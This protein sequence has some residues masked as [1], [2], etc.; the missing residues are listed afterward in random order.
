MPTHSYQFVL[1]C[2]STSDLAPRK[3]P[4]RKMP[5]SSSSS[6]SSKRSCQQQ[7]HNSVLFKYTTSQATRSL[8]SRL[9]SGRVPTA[10]LS[11]TTYVWSSLNF[12]SLIQLQQSATIIIDDTARKREIIVA[13][14]AC[15]DLK[16][17]IPRL[18]YGFLHIAW[19]VARESR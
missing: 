10:I 1:A 2:A 6:S 16:L 14:S 7:C 11:P 17:F 15:D 18:K 9:L 5:T 8:R 13:L 19:G 4:I 12:S 3:P